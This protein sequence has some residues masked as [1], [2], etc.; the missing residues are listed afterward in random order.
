MLTHLLDVGGVCPSAG[1]PDYAQTAYLQNR[2]WTLVYKIAGASKMK[3]TG[4]FNPELL[5]E[6]TDTGFKSLHSA[7]LS[8]ADIAQLCTD[9][10]RMHQNPQ[11]KSVFCAFDDIT[12]YGDG[13][14][15][16]GKRCTFDYSHKASDYISAKKKYGH[17]YLKAWSWGF[18][19]WGPT[20]NMPSIITQ[21]NYKDSRLGS[22]LCALC[23]PPKTGDCSGNGHCHTQVWCRTKVDSFSCGDGVLQNG[24]ECDDGNRDPADGCDS[25]CKLEKGFDCIKVSGGDVATVCKDIDECALDEK[26]MK[27]SAYS[28]NHRRLCDVKGVA[29]H[30]QRTCINSAGLYSQC[31]SKARTCHQAIRLSHGRCGVWCRG[32]PL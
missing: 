27:D 14:S 1:C 6:G 17:E 15:Y 31:S 18:G 28:R 13:K 11:A 21:L 19:T 23:T 22:H 25:A 9:Q 3:S 12:Q 10:Y 16:T 2:G 8:D 26:K 24:E 20:S 30:L 4:A 32:L 29:K 5:A 7:K